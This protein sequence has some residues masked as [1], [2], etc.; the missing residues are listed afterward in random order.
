MKKQSLK[1][2][3]G[4]LVRGEKFTIAGHGIG[5]RGQTVINGV[6]P[7]TKRKCKAVRPIVYTVGEM[8]SSS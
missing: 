1:I 4:Q 6:N 8:L 2:A 3:G 5:A 7:Y